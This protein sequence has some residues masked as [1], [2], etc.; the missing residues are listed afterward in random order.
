M[1]CNKNIVIRALFSDMDGTLMPDEKKVSEKNIYAIKKFV[2][3]GGEFTVAT[4]RSEL[5]APPFLDNIPITLP[6]ILYNG[7]VVYDFS[8]HRFLWKNCLADFIVYKILELAIKTYP[9]VCA[10]VFMGGPIRLVNRNCV[11]DHY[12]IEEDQPYIWS[13]IS[14]CSKC[15]KLLFYGEPEKLCL[16]EKKISS[17]G[18]NENFECISSAP[19]YLEVLPKGI[20]KHNALSWIV[21]NHSTKIETYAAI[22]DYYNDLQMV[23]NATLGAAP[24][25]AVNAVRRA[26]DIIVADNNHDALADLIENHI[27]LD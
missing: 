8:T 27:L 4:G 14:Q 22:G 17:V 25:N 20:S 1:K 3:R 9:N 15:I 24:N 6:A 5:I 2:T 23:K 10:E 21:R 18:S 12:I 19:F 26:A 7:A 16:L 11:M 13:E